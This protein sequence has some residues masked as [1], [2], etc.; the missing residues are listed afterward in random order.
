MK[1]FTAL[2]FIISIITFCS[3]EGSQQDKAEDAVKKYIKLNANVASSYE[4]VVYGQLDSLYRIDS[5]AYEALDME[6]KDI[7]AKYNS[8]K[9]E[10]NIEN[11][12]AFKDQLLQ[13]DQQMD[14]NRFLT[15]LRIYHVFNG[16]NREGTQ[17]INRG[18]F[19]LD[20]NFVVQDFIISE[21]SVQMVPGN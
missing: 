8:A 9:G 4:P 19:Y 20:T 6:R 11:T 5:S 10:G 1:I 15:G 21:D 18:S 7:V 12:K 2:L 13:V 14:K 17:V 3:S 16:K